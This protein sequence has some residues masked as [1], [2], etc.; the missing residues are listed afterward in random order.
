MRAADS[1]RVISRVVA[2]LLDCVERRFELLDLL[3]AR[4]VG[5]EDA[6]GSSP[7]FFARAISSPD[8]FCSRF[9]FSTCGISS[10]R[11][12]S[13]A[14]KRLEDGVGVEP[15]IAQAGTHFVAMIAH[16]TRDRACGLNPIPGT[17]MA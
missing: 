8:A 9:S 17:G 4:L 16:V 1:A 10:R 13:S 6:D 14:G 15:A 5:G 3:A 12:A 11:F 7:C 2:L